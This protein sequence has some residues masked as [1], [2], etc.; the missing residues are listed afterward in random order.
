MPITL[1][2]TVIEAYE[3][4][5]FSYKEKQIPIWKLWLI[6]YIAYTSVY[7]TLPLSDFQ[8]SLH[9]LNTGITAFFV[10]S[11][12]EKF[13]TCTNCALV[14]WYVVICPGPVYAGL[15][16]IKSVTRYYLQHGQG[17]FCIAQSFDFPLFRNT[18]N[19]RPYFGVSLL[20]STMTCVVLGVAM[21]LKLMRKT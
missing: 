17:Y 14:S 16:N 21:E 10:L 5:I 18:I 15:L 7:F 3:I 9:R 19:L 20:F 2:N 12:I 8:S 13:H 11:V 1:K 4:W 6:D